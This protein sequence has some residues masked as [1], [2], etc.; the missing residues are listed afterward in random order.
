MVTHSQL[1]AVISPAAAT[2]IGSKNEIIHKLCESELPRAQIYVL[3][4]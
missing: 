3:D 1:V 4:V 2:A